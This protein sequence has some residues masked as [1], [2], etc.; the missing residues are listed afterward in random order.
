M[1]GESQWQVLRSAVGGRHRT[2]VAVWIT[3]AGVALCS[4]TEAL[5]ATNAISTQQ[6]IAMALPAVLIT[7]VGI[8]GRIVPDAWIAWRRG[9]RHGC[10]AALASQEYALPPEE[11]VSR[12]GEIRL[13][14]LAAYRVHRYCGVCGRG[15]S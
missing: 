15:L 14:R 8:V 6:A 3:A 11:E 1:G 4:V 7:V 5:S 12:R 13:A 9:F 2:R 10:E